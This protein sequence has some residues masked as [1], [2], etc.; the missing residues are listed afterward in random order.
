MELSV[1]TNRMVQEASDI[2]TVF[3]EMDNRIKRETPPY[4]PNGQ[5]WGP[6]IYARAADN[7]KTL[8]S[9]AMQLDLAYDT[10]NNAVGEDDNGNYTI[11][12]NDYVVAA[13]RYIEELNK[14]FK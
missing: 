4:A 10:L 6:T 7:I 8:L 12:S 9:I 13:D 1:V 5:P 2:I 14:R 3:R 11:I